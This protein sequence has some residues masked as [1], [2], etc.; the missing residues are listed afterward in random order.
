[1]ADNA[2]WKVIDT[3]YRSNSY[4]F[5]RHHIDSY[6]DLVFNKIPYI[7]SNLN[8]FVVLK[9]N[10][11]IETTVHRESVVALP[12]TYLKSVEDGERAPLYP[13]VAR[14]QNRSYLAD[15]RA[16]VTVAYYDESDEKVNEKHFKNKRIGS[17]P[18]LLH[19]KLCYLRGLNTEQLRKLGECPYDQ[20]GY[21]VIDGKEKVIISQERIA[22]NQLF[23]SDPQDDERDM[24][25]GMIRSTSL[26]NALFPKTVRF[27]IEKQRNYPRA[28]FVSV[29]IMRVTKA[30]LPLFLVFRALG[31]E[32][33]RDII[34]HIALGDDGI[35]DLL[36]E[37]AVNASSVLDANDQPVNLYSQ[38]AALSYL[39]NFTEH[40]NPDFVKFLLVDNLFPNIGDDFRQKAM[41]LGYLTNT[42]IK[43][44][45]GAIKQ[46]KRDNYMFKRVD[47]TGVLLGNIFRDFYN[48]FRNHA[49]ATIDREYTQSGT[50]NRLNV[51]T[52]SNFERV[53]PAGIIHE[54]LY[55]SMKGKWGLTGDPSEQGIVQDL[56]RLSYVSYVSH[57]RRVN[58]PID[59][60]IKLVEPHRLDS[61]QFGMMCPIESPDGGN[62]GLLKHM[63]ATCEITRES[64]R[65]DMLACLD[66]LDTVPLRDVDPY[67]IRGRAKILLNNN[68]IGV[69]EDPHRLVST[70]REY[71]RTGVLNAFVSIAW[72]I[73]ENEVVVFTD[74]GRCCRP[75]IVVPNRAALAYDAKEWADELVR[76][77]TYD[78]TYRRPRGKRDREAGENAGRGGAIEYI[79]CFETNGAY[80]AMKPKDLA[81]E[82]NPR[83][84]HMELHPCLHMSMYTNTIPLANHNQAPRNVFSGQQGKQALGIYATSFNNRIDT[85]SY[86]LH[87]PQRPLLSTKMAKYAFKNKMPNGEN[88]IVAI[89]TYTG[90]NQEDSVILN[91]SSIARG[92]FNVSAFKSIVESEDFNSSQNVEMLFDNPVELQNEGTS[93]NYKY[94]NWDLLDAR[95][96]P[97]RNHHIG[98]NDAYLGMVK[99]EHQQARGADDRQ[100]I[101]SDQSVRKVYKDVSKVAGK[102]LSGV[103]DDVIDYQLPNGYRQ[104]KIRVRKF[105]IPELGDKMASTHGQKGVCG[106]ILPQED[107]PHNKHGL[108]P[109][110][111][112]NPHAFPS[113]MTIGHLVECVLA[114]L[115]CLRGS[116][117][118]GTAFEDNCIPDYYN[119]MEKYG[120]HKHGDEILYNG[121]TGDQIATEIFFGPTFYQRLKHMVKDKINYRAG[122]PVELLTRQ[123]TQ[124]RANDGGLRIGEMETNAI[125]GHGIGAFIKESM[126]T[127]SDGYYKY[128][129]GETGED[130]VYNEATGYF[131]SLNATKVS[132]P[133]SA[134]LL[135]QEL[136]AMSIESRLITSAK[137]N[138]E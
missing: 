117:V 58:T 64:S 87:H 121:Y 118:D 38:G 1:M 9:D 35:R 28:F 123:P 111:I 91:G 94:A 50:T 110:I 26:T 138:L 53:F 8:P 73:V 83:H 70:L 97:K 59:R 22:T 102:T 119:M 15:L 106:M 14:L 16:D 20:G 43:T 116:Y 103:V 105:K 99:V 21:F 11:R 41:Y 74:A 12:P 23:I 49:R 88:L 3:Y 34:D 32:S 125:L 109:D 82:E 93:I 63:A 92:M 5:T 6:D 134:K 75:L 55:K 104:V 115:C 40:N 61:P 114:K 48:T 95:G 108:V 19:S 84:T 128:V 113:R 42:L 33:D 71:R 79:D 4:Y 36:R 7:V 129:D 127:R 107:M 112:V 78:F 122:G 80:I 51:V 81:P 133:Y 39:A 27:W 57:V 62:I 130:I 135:Q 96:F 29:N 101:F 100:V 24:L 90:Y 65:E 131:T 136:G 89:A 31:V 67:N 76:G 137:N 47:T 66:D 10:L 44:N 18:V 30:R 68:W 2:I 45:I 54:G 124:G 13:N 46:N 72:K 25:D 77:Y 37:S 85:A 126:T 60:S 17:I 98:E 132:I 69:H 120:Y 56:S 86:V 52:E